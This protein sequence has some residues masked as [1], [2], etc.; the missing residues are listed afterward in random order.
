MMRQSAAALTC[1]LLLAA[2]C[3]PETASQAGGIDAA[4]DLIDEAALQAHLEYLASDELEGR[5]TG[6]PGY[7]AGIAL[8]SQEAINGSL[9]LLQLCALGW[10]L[11]PLRPDPRS[12]MR[13]QT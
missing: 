12:G 11:I 8:S 7:V 5:E 6:Q 4:V 3:Q 13:P 2:G 10:F 1:G 9:L